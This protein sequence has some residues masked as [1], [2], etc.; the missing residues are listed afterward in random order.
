MT[1]LGLIDDL[2]SRGVT[3]S[4]RGDKL[5]A[6]GLVDVLSDALRVT[7]SEWKPELLAV[8]AGDW[9]GAAGAA[10]VHHAGR[11]SDDDWWALDAEF[12]RRVQ[13]LM[14]AGAERR[15]AQKRAYS[16][17]AQ[18]AARLGPLRRRITWHE[19]HTV[20]NGL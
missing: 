16:E 19:Q 11:I 12:M 18:S 9:F 2:A 20:N 4:R 8:L 13:D 6:D 17:L 14:K 15:N 10:L 3:L 7:L 5:R 1:A